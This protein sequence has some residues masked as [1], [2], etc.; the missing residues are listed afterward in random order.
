MIIKTVQIGSNFH[1][2]TVLIPSSKGSIGT[3]KGFM[4][5]LT[6]LL[7]QPAI[8]WERWH[9]KYQDLHALLIAVAVLLLPLPYSL[10]HT[11][12]L[13]HSVNSA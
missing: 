3:G 5:L 13:N 8:G 12:A 10:V 2:A 1:N 9:Q 7:L 6:F 11:S 4:V